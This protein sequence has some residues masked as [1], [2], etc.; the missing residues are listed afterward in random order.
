M[1]VSRLHD[2]P[3]Q[4]A[5]LHR[6]VDPGAV[7]ARGPLPLVGARVGR[8]LVHEF[9]VAVGLDGAHE[10]VGHRDADVE[11]RKIAVVLGMDEGFDI[12]VVAAQYAHLRAAPRARGFDRLATA[13]EHA[14]IG[15]R[16]AGARMRAAHVRAFRPDRRKI[17]A[18]AAA[19]PHGFRGFH[20]RDVDAGPAINRLGNRVADG[21]HETIDQ[22]RLQVGAGGGIHASARNESADQRFEERRLPARGIVLDR[23][24]RARYPAPHVVSGLLVA[25]SVLFQQHIDADLLLRQG[26]LGIVGFHF[27]ALISTG[28]HCRYGRILP[29]GRAARTGAREYNRHRGPLS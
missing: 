6:A 1:I 16:A 11:V 14:H 27:R 20:Q 13:V 23:G 26:E 3:P 5:R 28:I 18:D 17:V 9:P 24:Q 8:R 2:L 4:V 7:L 25:F 12:G 22:G 21:L 29:A 15:Y 10:R 19:A